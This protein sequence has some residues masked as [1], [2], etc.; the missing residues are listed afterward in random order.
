MRHTHELT[1]MFMPLFVTH[2]CL[3]RIRVSTWNMVLQ[4]KIRSYNINLSSWPRDRSTRSSRVKNFTFST[5]SRW[6]RDSAVSRE[7]GY[8]LNDWA[9]GGQ[10]PVGLNITLPNASRW[11]RVLA[12]SREFLRAERPRDRSTS[13][14]RVKNFTF[15]TSSR[16]SRDSAVSR[17]N[18]YGLNDREIRVQV[19]VRLRTLP[20]PPRPDGAAIAQSVEKLATGWTTERSEYKFL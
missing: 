10:V 13:S 8:G 5:S 17:E 19:P 9:I 2:V 6:S 1:V 7:T 11:S 14:S 12:V 18:G 4:R 16:W 3:I 15:S 20:S